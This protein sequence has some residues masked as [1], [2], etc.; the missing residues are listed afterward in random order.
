MLP[1]AI[2]AIAALVAG[3][4]AA[5]AGGRLHVP[6]EGGLRFR[7]LQRLPEHRRG[8]IAA[9][10]DVAQLSGLALTVA[11]A[12]ITLGGLVVALL[13]LL[14]RSS[15]YLV[16][17]DSAAARWGRPRTSDLGLQLLHAVTSMGDTAGVAIVGVVVVAI[18]LR[19]LSNRWLVPFLLVVTFGN[20]LAT[21]LIKAAANRARPTLDPLAATLGPSF[22]SGH[23]ST[24]AAFYA[25]VALIL[26]R[27]RS[28]VTRAALAGAAVAIA[29]AVAGSR[30][31]L[32]LHWLSDVIAGLALGWAWF[33]AC[34]VVFGGRILRPGAGV[35]S[36]LRPASTPASP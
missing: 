3:A 13:A 7:L 11:L 30:V 26:A 15:G 6:G 29:V 27:R 4:I 19:R 36:D 14:V 24:A 18:E 35:T 25:A 28:P 22:P 32:D 20:V 33:A 17:L 2:L 8:R 16:E 5:L 10:L 31:L 12:V 1:V 9:R 34:A 21:T 23:S